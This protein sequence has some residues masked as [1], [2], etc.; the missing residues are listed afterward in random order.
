MTIQPE[1]D[2]TYLLTLDRWIVAPDGEQYKAVFGKITAVS[3][4]KDTLG[5][6]T[7][8]DSTN[9][10]VTIGSMIIAGCQI[11]YAIQTD[12]ISTV[13]PSHVID[14]KGKQRVGKNN[15]SLIYVTV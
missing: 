1:L 13:P 4:A 12:K 8:K 3:S 2:K 5:I 15:K 6:E 7:N 9:W 11:H 10:Y 14:Y